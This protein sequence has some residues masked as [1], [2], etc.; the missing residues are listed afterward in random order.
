LNG[1]SQRKRKLP[2]KGQIGNKK[3]KG[4]KTVQ[5]SKPKVLIKGSSW[6]Q[7]F[8][9][10]HRMEKRK[11]KKKEVFDKVNSKKPTGGSEISAQ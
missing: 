7:A 5:S 11:L 9:I 1:E 4:L 3:E 10:K 6:S 8:L 2:I